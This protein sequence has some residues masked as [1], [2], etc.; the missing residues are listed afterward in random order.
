MIRVLHI[1]QA[2]GGVERYLYSLYKYLDKKEYDHILVCSLDYEIGKFEA[3]GITIVQLEMNREINLIQDI[4]IILKLRQILNKYKPDIVYMHSSKAGAAGRIAN[5]GLSNK[6]IYNPHGWSFN[7]KCNV[8]KKS[9]YAFIERVLAPLCTKIIAISGYEKDSALK[10]HICNETK[11]KVIYNGIDLEEHLK[12]ANKGD[13]KLLQQIPQ[14]AF[15]VGCV[16]R[17]TEQKAP[18]VFIRAARLIKDSIPNACFLFVGGGEKENEVRELISTLGLEGC[19]FITGWVDNPLTYV[20]KMDVAMLLSR[21]EGF[22]LVIPEY[23]LEGKPVIATKIDAIPNLIT[24]RWNGILIDVDDY[25]SAS[26]SCIELYNNPTLVNSL[27]ENAKTTV[28]NRFD[29][30]R[31]ALEH[32]QL[33]KTILKDKN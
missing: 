11:I 20:R 27:I 15:V 6:S 24:D 23:M 22:G 16:G 32:E 9:F 29:A 12:E 4:K 5:F 14:N 13:I 26:S 2:P 31:V 30:K 28:Y 17:L 19:V 3:L 33:F 8:I 21:W 7:M 25:H 1:A 18:D 10:R